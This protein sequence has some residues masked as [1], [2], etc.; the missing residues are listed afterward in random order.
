[1]YPQSFPQKLSYFINAALALRSCVLGV[2]SRK[3]AEAEEAEEEGQNLDRACR[4]IKG[5]LNQY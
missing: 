5:L 1:M 4:L 3:E 2:G